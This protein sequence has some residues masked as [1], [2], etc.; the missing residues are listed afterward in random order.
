[1]VSVE[2]LPELCGW[3]A[4]ASP[5]FHL[6]G[7]RLYGR[8]KHVLNALGNVAPVL[9]MV[10]YAEHA[11]A[12][13]WATRLAARAVLVDRYTVILQFIF[14]NRT[15][16]RLT[17]VSPGRMGFSPCGLITPHA[18]RKTHNTIR[19]IGSIE[20]IPILTDVGGFHMAV[21]IRSTAANTPRK[22][23]GLVFM[24]YFPGKSFRSLV[25]R[26]FPAPGKGGFSLY[27]A[28]IM[29]SASLTL[30]HKLAHR[31]PSPLVKKFKPVNRSILPYSN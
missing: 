1:M 17:H 27:Q 8:P 16:F 6:I 18:S 19:A 7:K 31:R 4:V 23:A 29:C 14:L 5:Q 24:V 11:V 15:T 20:A 25:I 2:L 26:C 10:L 12:S 3:A 28:C 30:A 22:S 9:Q 21:Q 13:D